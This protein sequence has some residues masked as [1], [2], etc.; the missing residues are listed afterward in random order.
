MS[1]H[2]KEL[3]RLGYVEGQNLLIERYS[4]EGRAAEG[5]AAYYPGLAR[6]V[7]ARKPDL[8]LAVE[9]HVVLDFKAETTT[10]PIVA[11][12]ADPVAFG[13]VP[14]LARPGGNITGVSALFD[15][16]IWS[17]RV[18][19]L[20]EL[21]PRASRM[22]FL[23]SHYAWETPMGAVVRETAQKI[24]VSLIGPPVDAPYHEAEYRRVLALMAK[25]GM[26]ALIVGDH[27]DTLKNR[28]LIVE[29][30]EK[31]RLPA[32]YPFREYMEVGGLMAYAFDPVDLGRHAAQQ[33]DLIL[34]GTKPGDIPFYQST[35][36]A[37]IINLRTAKTLGIDMPSSLLAST[38]E[39]IE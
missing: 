23:A 37:L 24:G 17:K 25:E 10:I 18:E 39:V 3:R 20:R 12:V 9:N 8:I 31:G 4:G 15:I 1:A 19:L 35:K 28:R 34:R 27:P 30:A 7:I 14:N 29:F 11:G 32:I 26:E 13:I 33:I 16:S 36:L 21:A 22:G 38:D 6:E 5:K 2:L